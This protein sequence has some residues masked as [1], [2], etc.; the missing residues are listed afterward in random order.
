[1]GNYEGAQVN[2][3]GQA[4]ITGFNYDRCNDETFELD[5]IFS[6]RPDKIEFIYCNPDSFAA[7]EGRVWAVG[8]QE[9]VVLVVAS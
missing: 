9:Y 6:D 4:E 5:I 3:E 7:Q 8:L 2:Y 1:M